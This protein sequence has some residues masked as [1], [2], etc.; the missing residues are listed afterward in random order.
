MCDS[1]LVN[2]TGTQ[3]TDKN[4]GPL[5]AEAH[6]KPAKNVVN[7]FKACGIEPFSP[8]IFAP[9]TTTERDP[10]SEGIDRAHFK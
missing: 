9:A 10:P 5:F 7:G 4:L 6:G 2:H 1:F 8:L 3:I